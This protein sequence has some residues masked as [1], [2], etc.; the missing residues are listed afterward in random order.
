MKHN[1]HKIRRMI[2]VVCVILLAAWFVYEYVDSQ[3]WPLRTAEALEMRDELKGEHPELTKLTMEF[4]FPYKVDIRFYS[5]KWNAHQKEA[6]V[7]SVQEKILDPAFW[8][9]FVSLHERR[10][11]TEYREQRGEASVVM[12][13]YENGESV[14]V[15]FRSVKFPESAAE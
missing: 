6:L 7:Q 4:R 5:D 13:F 15:Y 3:P 1:K 9:A 12:N 10:Y 11:G 14:P 2:L 8:D